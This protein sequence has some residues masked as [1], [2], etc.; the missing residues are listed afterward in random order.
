MVTLTLNCKVQFQICT[1]YSGHKRQLQM[2]D[3]GQTTDNGQCEGYGKS[4]SQVS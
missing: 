1:S 2:Q 3:E 4:S